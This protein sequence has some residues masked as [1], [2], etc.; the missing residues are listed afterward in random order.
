MLRADC[1]IHIQSLAILMQLL[2]DLCFKEIF[3]GMVL[4]LIQSFILFCSFLFVQKRLFIQKLQVLKSRTK[5]IEVQC[6]CPQ[7]ALS[8]D[9]I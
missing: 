4:P 2:E 1:E 9:I 6:D 8:P 7:M 3:S 5:D